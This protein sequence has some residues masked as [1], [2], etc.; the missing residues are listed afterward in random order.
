[1]WFWFYED[2]GKTYNWGYKNE[3]AVFEKNLLKAFQVEGPG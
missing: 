2:C 3:D 1:L